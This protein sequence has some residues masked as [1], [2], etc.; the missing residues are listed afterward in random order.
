MLFRSN[1]GAALSRRGRQREGIP[2]LER[3]LT[4]NPPMPAVHNSLA[5]AYLSLGE[6][7]KGIEHFRASLAIA[8]EQPQIQQRLSELSDTGS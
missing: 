1:L 8:P 2:Y 6:R 3:A 7:D 5:N 4:L